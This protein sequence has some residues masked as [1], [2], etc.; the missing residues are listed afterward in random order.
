MGIQVFKGFYANPECQFPIGIMAG[1]FKPLE[2]VQGQAG[3]PQERME[4][5]NGVIQNIQS[6]AFQDDRQRLIQYWWWCY[7]ANVG[8]VRRVI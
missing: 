6:T 2:F 7:V 1:F 8:G 5:L 4:S 3:A